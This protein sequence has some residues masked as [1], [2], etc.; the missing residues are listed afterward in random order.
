MYNKYHLTPDYKKI[1]VVVSDGYTELKDYVEANK[2]WHY[3]KSIDGE[4]LIRDTVDSFLSETEYTVPVFKVFVN[5]ENV[6]GT[7][8]QKE[9]NGDFTDICNSDYDPMDDEGEF[10]EC[11]YNSFDFEF[12]ETE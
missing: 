4:E 5:V 9:M 1:S 10:D 2:N 3:M 6:D 8:E 7:T 11:Y 12:L